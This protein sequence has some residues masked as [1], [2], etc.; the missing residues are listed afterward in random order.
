MYTQ[1][2][3]F[4]YFLGAGG[5]GKVFRV[6]PKKGGRRNAVRAVKIVVGHDNIDSLVHESEIMRALKGKGVAVEF[7]GMHVVRKLGVDV[8]AG[9]IME[10]V[11]NHISKGA[12]NSGYLADALRVLSNNP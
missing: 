9:L 2:N 3:T 5:T 1:T 10:P 6:Y 8:G 7:V 11:G 4:R 12:S